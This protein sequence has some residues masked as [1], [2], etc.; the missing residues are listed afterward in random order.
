MRLGSQESSDDR[1]ERLLSDT[2]KYLTSNVLACQSAG[3]YGEVSVSLRFQ[4]GE[5]SCVDRV[6]K[7]TKK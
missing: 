2:V 1:A 7:E 5:I 4:N 6:I 3:W